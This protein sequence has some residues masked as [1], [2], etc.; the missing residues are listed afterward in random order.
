VNVNCE[1]VDCIAP[2]DGIVWVYKVNDIKG[3][4][5]NSHGGILPKGHVDIDFAQ[6]LDSLV[7]E[8]V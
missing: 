8:A 4:D 2:E 5:F 6:C 1:F 7:A 3:D